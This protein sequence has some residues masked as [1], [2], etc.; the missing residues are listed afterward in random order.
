MRV[1]IDEDLS[2]R[3]AAVLCERGVYASHVRDLGLSGAT[4]HQLFRYAYEHDFLVVTA[5]VED[6]R[7]LAERS[8]LHCGV[9]LLGGAQYTRNEQIALVAYALELIGSRDMANTVLHLSKFGQP[10]FEHLPRC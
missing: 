8:E 4:D 1:L 7:K 3:C 10:R 9:V 6:F 2:P 5:N